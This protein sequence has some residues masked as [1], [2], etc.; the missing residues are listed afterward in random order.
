MV[1]FLS[2]LIILSILASKVSSRFGLPLLIGFILIGIIVGSDVLNLVYFDNADLT[3]RV[4]DILLI[5]II[6]EGGFRITRGEFRSV[7]GPS[8]TLATLGVA[9]TSGILGLI[10]H[11]ALG[12]DLIYSLL[13]SS[14]ISST[15]AAAVFMITRSNPIKS[16]L[17]STL[18]IESAANDPMAIIL[19]VTFIQIAMQ[20]FRSP[21]IAIL[22]LLWQFAG[23]II[24]GYLAFRISMFVFHHLNSES[25]GNYNILMLGC[26]L[27]AYGISD[28]LK[29]NGII[30]VFFMGYWLGNANFPAKRSVSGFLESI[31]AMFNI[32]LFIMLGLL[33]FPHRFAAVWKE[34]LI[35]VAVMMFVAR[36]FAL[37]ISTI[38]FKYSAK[39]KVFL[40]WGGIKGAV[41]I[42]LATYPLASGL[43]SSGFIFDVIF[44]AVFL[45]CIIQGTTLG[46]LAK[47][48]SF[49]ERRRL[50]SPHTIELHS[51]RS[52]NVEMAEVRVDENS[53][54]IDRPISE[55]N[56]DKDLLISSIV[57]DGQIVLPKGSTVVKANDIL[58]VLAP[59]AKVNELAVKL[60]GV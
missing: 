45:S 12:F 44:F 6:F 52:S 18:N 5:F 39:E 55:M 4:A 48:F 3:K 13:I 37:F 22:S 33:A 38:P 1:L 9:L 59:S 31:A 25:R 47:A 56:L 58:Y 41:P 53:P 14:I 24:I 32:A 27:F 42:V 57:R 40:M 46:L 10:I 34:A 17:A 49:T 20:S 36:P 21:L 35:I 8:L 43:D 29:A 51:L 54:C 7:A 2:L 28:A 19:T 30:A 50:E 15:D 11:F 60:N 26:I 16:K 23:G